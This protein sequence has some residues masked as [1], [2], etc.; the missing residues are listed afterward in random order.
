MRTKY[1]LLLWIFCFWAITSCETTGNSGDDQQDMNDSSN[2]EEEMESTPEPDLDFGVEIEV[3]S[4]LEVY[5]MNDGPITICVDEI[6]TFVSISENVPNGVEWFFFNADPESFSEEEGVFIVPGDENGYVA[7]TSDLVT[8][9]YDKPGKYDLQLQSV[10]VNQLPDNVNIDPYVLFKEDYICVVE[11]KTACLLDRIESDDGFVTEYTFGTYKPFPKL[12]RVDNLF[13]GALRDYNT[14]EYN[15]AGKLSRINYFDPDDV[16]LGASFIEYT[17]EDFLAEELRETS[18]GSL[19]F[20][21]TFN[22]SENQVTG[23]T[24]ETPDGVGGTSITDIDYTYNL[25]NTNIIEEIFSQNGVVLARV[26][27]EHDDNPKIESD[28]PIK[29]YPVYFNANN[30]ISRITKDATG[31]ILEEYAIT[32]QYDLVFCNTAIQSTEV[33]TDATG[34]TVV[35]K[36]F[37]YGKL[38]IPVDY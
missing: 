24:L 35:N 26:E 34:T 12:S 20:K 16:K 13:N 30:I 6:V 31:N 4:G 9:S 27:Y 5:G 28:L 10:E 38:E 7:T 33:T 14:F 29:T 23:A 21:Y 3:P 37:A 22:Y 8:V 1:F 19:V 32:Y 11:C 36:Q 18:D 15:D 25:E 2:D 17:L